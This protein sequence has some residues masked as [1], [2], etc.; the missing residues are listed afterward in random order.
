M[1][2][3]EWQAARNDKAAICYRGSNARQELKDVCDPVLVGPWT[4]WPQTWRY[5]TPASSETMP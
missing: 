5:G 3:G 4:F 2:Q 1:E